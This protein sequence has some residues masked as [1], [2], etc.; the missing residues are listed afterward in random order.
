MLRQSVR[1]PFLGSLFR[2]GAD[3]AAGA[4]SSFQANFAGN[5][6]PTGGGAM[7]N[8]F[9][10]LNSGQGVMSPLQNGDFGSFYDKALEWCSVSHAQQ[11][12]QRMGID[13][14]DVKF[15]SLPDGQVRVIVDAPH[16]TPR[17]VEEL[18]QAVMQ[19][20]PL[21]RFRQSQVKD[22]EKQ[23]KWLRLSDKYDR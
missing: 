5:V 10:A 4:S 20:C 16:A 12:A 19:E 9:G 15:E 13:M 1:R 17:Q 22:P 21:A 23:M 18:G 6:K 2:R 8:F 14:R 3:A 11:I 7:P